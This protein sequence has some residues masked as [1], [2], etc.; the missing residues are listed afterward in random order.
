MPL[1]E[2]DVAAI[3]PEAGTPSTDR[4]PDWVATGTPEPLRFQLVD[5]LGEDRVLSRASD[6]IRY[7]SDAS[8]YRKLPQVVIMAKDAGDVGK[9]LE[10]GRRTGMPVTFRAGGTRLNGQGQTD[11]ILV[12]VRKHFGGVTVL[13]LALIHLSEPTRP[14]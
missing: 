6:I 14:S 13:D 3:A 9:V 1:L 4:A 5:L 2:S 8:P 7:A 11:S 10:Y 12:D